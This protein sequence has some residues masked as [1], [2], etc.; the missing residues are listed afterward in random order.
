MDDQ[1]RNLRNL[2]CRLQRFLP[3][4]AHPRPALA[5]SIRKI[6]PRAPAAPLLSVNCIFD[7]GADRGLMCRIE[8]NGADLHSPTFV[9]PIT[10]VAF[11]RR[12][13]ISRE[14]AAYGKRCFG[15]LGWSRR[16]AALPRPPVSGDSGRDRSTSP[17]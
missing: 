8:L 2:I 4:A 15:A 3:L 9:A 6:A 17:L 16:G 1:S 14:V 10:Q 7:A 12:H 11:D 13:P 5:A